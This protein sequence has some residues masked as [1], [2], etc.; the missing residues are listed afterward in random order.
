MNKTGK[1]KPGMLK[2]YLF[3]GCFLWGWGIW[4]RSQCRDRHF[5][6]VHLSLLLLSWTTGSFFCLAKLPLKLILNIETEPIFLT[7]PQ[8]REVT[9]NADAFFVKNHYFSHLLIMLSICIQY[10]SAFKNRFTFRTQNFKLRNIDLDPEEKQ[11][12]AKTNYTFVM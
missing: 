12:T 11:K 10:S 9:I 7:R 2:G 3:F 4:T 1:G 8:G 5:P 6:P